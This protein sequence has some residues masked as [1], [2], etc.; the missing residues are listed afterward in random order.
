MR[1]NFTADQWAN[2]W[3][4]IE[5]LPVDEQAFGLMVQW[6]SYHY[7]ATIGPIV[8][9]IDGYFTDFVLMG[10]RAILSVDAWSLSLAFELEE[11]RDRVL[12]DLENS[13]FAV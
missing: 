11:V 9:S 12:A 6:I 2:G 13:E 3:A 1:L 4:S 7:G 8:D 10:S 5:M